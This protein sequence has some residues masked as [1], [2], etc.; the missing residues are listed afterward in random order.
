[1]HVNNLSETM[2]TLLD[3]HKP[4]RYPLYKATCCT[5]TNLASKMFIKMM[6]KL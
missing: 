2:V 1:M 6:G 3:I 4:A 5:L